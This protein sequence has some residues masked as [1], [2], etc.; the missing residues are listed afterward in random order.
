MHPEIKDGGHQVVWNA[1]TKTNIQTISQT[2]RGMREGAM[3]LDGMNNEIA[4]LFKVGGKGR[5]GTF[6][7]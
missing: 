6:L 4:A 7:V 3:G 5:E 1:S 2:R